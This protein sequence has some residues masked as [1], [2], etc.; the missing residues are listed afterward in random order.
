MPRR[1]ILTLLACALFLRVMVP[2]G[3]MPATGGGLFAIELCPAAAP[4]PIIHSMKDHGAHHA[5][6]PGKQHDSGSCAFAPM[7]SAAAAPELAAAPPSPP[8][9][10]TVLSAGFVSAFLPTGPPASPPPARGPPALA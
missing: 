4:A 6:S 7:Q 5:P 2:A 9:A 8:I 3:W 1:L 10:D